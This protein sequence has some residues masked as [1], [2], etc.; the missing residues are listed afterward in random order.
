MHKQ[1]LRLFFA[2]TFG[3]FAVQAV[4]YNNLILTGI[5]SVLCYLFC[6]GFLREMK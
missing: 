4:D 3:A 6:W 5:F 1:V 2:I